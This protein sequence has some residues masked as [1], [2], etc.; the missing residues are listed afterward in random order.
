MN[1]PNKITVSRIILA[2]IILIMLVIPWHS[3]GVD[4][5]SYDSMFGFE[6]DSPLSLKYIV[7]G[8]LFLVASL[9]DRIDGQIARKRNMVTDLGKMLDAIADKILVN[10]VIIILAYDHIIPLLVPVVI[11][12]RDIITDTCKMVSGNKGKVVAASWTGKVKTA[13]MMT[14]VTLAFF[15]NLPFELVHF[16]FTGICLIVATV[17][18]L[19]SGCQYYFNTMKLL[20]EK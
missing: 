3:L 10:G 17:L 15:G 2:I 13:F 5:A 8:F 1:L 16:D 14:G 6:L 19:V 4:W 12:T 9:T 18:S 20:K 11:I 7:T